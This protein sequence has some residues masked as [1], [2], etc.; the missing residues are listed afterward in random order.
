M[1]TEIFKFEE[2]NQITALAKQLQLDRDVLLR[3]IPI[4][5]LGSLPKRDNDNDQIDSD[6]FKLNRISTYDGVLPIER[7][8]RNAAAASELD[9]AAQKSFRTWADDALERAK[10]KPVVG[11]PTAKATDAA[12]QLETDLP[13]KVFFESDLLEISFLA[14]ANRTARSVARIIVTRYDNGNVRTN[15][16]TGRPMRYFGTCWLIGSKHVI[17]NHHVIGARN[18]GEAAATAE[19]FEQQASNSTIEFDYDSPT[20]EVTT[21]QIANLVVA[22]P[23]LDFAI[24]ELAPGVPLQ[25][26]VL[27][28]AVNPLTFGP[29]IYLPV[30]IIQHPGGGIKHLAIR[31]NA[32]AGLSGND[33]SYFTDTQAGSSGSP[34]CNDKWGVIALHKAST[35]RY[36]KTV[37]QGRE[38]PWV[39]IGTPIWLIAKVLKDGDLWDKIDPTTV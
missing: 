24:L 19:D 21:Y 6:F 26:D 1:A 32:A 15:P 29:G 14:A 10:P 33:L 4:P 35:K 39:N 12:E 2:A 11:S 30:N 20:G 22:D 16:A 38:N 17:T 9:Q 5:V 31:N 18:P 7:W 28:L 27:P 13:E 3:W 34:V 23:E 36:G 8:L 37:Y 25:R